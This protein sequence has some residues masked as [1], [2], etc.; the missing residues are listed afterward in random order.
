MPRDLSVTVRGEDLRLLAERALF[1]PRTGTLLVA[2]AHWGKAAA[3][4]ASAVPVPGE[5][6]AADL[7]RLAGALAR[8][9]ARRLVVLGDLL[10]AREGRD[11]DTFAAVAGW[12]AAHRGLEVV[13][14]RGN[15]DR[16]AGDP[17]ADWGFACS[18]E[19]LP[20]PP[21]V[22]RHHPEES[23]DGY[24]LAGHVHP[25]VK[26]LGRGRQRVRA[27]C[28][29]FGPRVGLLPAFGSFTGLALVEPRRGDRVFVVADGEVLD[30]SPP[31]R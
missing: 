18:A 31:Q 6:T 21:F 26:L 10:H 14:V 29:H 16:R 8:T 30:V 9:G 17:P 5:M 20:E 11:P 2:D 13:L 7:S 27:A 4:R 25:G 3:F 19:P 12:R 28:F 22:L 24:V 15:H 23:P 1:V